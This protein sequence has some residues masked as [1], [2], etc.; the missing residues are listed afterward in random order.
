M[1]I[2]VLAGGLSTERDVS[3]STGSM[4]CNALCEYGHKTALVD[5][6]LGISDYR[7]NPEQYFNAQPR[8][9]PAVP[10]EAP[11]LMAVK[12]NRVSCSKSFF[13][14][15]VLEIC[16]AADK[17]FIA[18]HG[19]NGEDGRVQATLDLMG[20]AYTGTG[21]LGSALAMDKDMSKRLLQSG[22]V[23]TAKWEFVNNYENFTSDK[24]GFPCVVKPCTGGSSVGVV[25]ANTNE[26]REKALS[27]ALSFGGGAIVEDYVTGR[28]FSVGVLEGKALEPIEIVPH[29]GFYDFKN[30]YQ[31]GLTDEICP[32]NMTNGEKEK[33]QSLAS[34]AHRILRLGSYSR[35][36]FI[37]DGSD[38]FCLEANTL[39]GLTPT[40]LLPQEAAAQGISYGELCQRL[41]M[42]R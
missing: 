22:G 39:P 18:L 41:V 25:I 16:D 7:G 3:L 10:E 32:A 12:N 5:A 37:Y 24:I 8:V 40:S 38:F 14:P 6:Y 11:D 29:E 1:N 21:Y 20:I 33:I 30:K 27:E 13:G 42:A 34:A 15:G 19:E 23:P 28:E 26:Q 2:A 9:V 36:D 31:A 17:V 35:I 4:V